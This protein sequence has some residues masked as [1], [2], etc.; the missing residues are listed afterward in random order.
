MN[1]SILNFLTSLKEN[2]NREWFQQNKEP[3]REKT[4]PWQATIFNRLY[5]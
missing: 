1:E 2:N 3:W 5:S 4:H